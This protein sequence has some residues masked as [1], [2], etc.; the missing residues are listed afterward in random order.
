MAHPD[1]NQ[2]IKTSRWRDLSLIGA[3]SVGAFVLAS[4]IAESSVRVLIFV[5]AL[6]IF[7][8]PGV[9]LA[10]RLFSGRA[11]F[12]RYTMGAALGYLLGSLSASVF[13]RAG[14]LSPV[15]MGLASL[16]LTAVLA[17]W[18]RESKTSS[19]ETLFGTRFWLTATLALGLGLVAMPFLRV[20]EQT[21]EGDAYRAYFSA[22]LMTHLSVV[23][24]LQK[25]DFPPQNPF[26][27]G[28][29]LGY[30]WLFFLFPALLG[31]WIGNQQALLL[32]DLAG[33]C[34]FA[35]LAFAAANRLASRPNLAFGAVGIGLVAASYEGVAVLLRAAW[36]GEPV[37]SFKSVNV[38]AFSRWF[39][40]LTSLDGLHR[41]LL[42]TPQHLYSYSL[43]LVLVL[44]L[45]HGELRG[46]THSVVAGFLVGGMAGMSIV[47]A[48]IVGPWLVLS[49]FLSGGDRKT[50]LRDLLL[51]GVTA[52]GCLAWYFELGFFGDAGGELALRLPRLAD[53]PAI[54]FL[55]AGPLFL[56]GL[57]ALAERHL[58]RLGW[59]AGIAF[60]ATLFLDIGTA[61]GVWLAWRAGSVLLIALMLMV[62][63]TLRN[64]RPAVLLVVLLPATLTCALDLFNAQDITNRELSRGEFRWTTVVDPSDADALAWIR[65]HSA[66]EA[67]VQWDV[68]ARE[69]GEWA[70]IPA[71]AERRLAVGFPIFLLDNRRY[72]IRER[73]LRPM[74]VSS[75]PDEAHRLAKEAGIDYL[76][77]GSRE[78]TLRGE[79]VRKF[80]EAPE[81]FRKVYANRQATVFQVFG[82]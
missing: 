34:L 14:I 35:A 57:P 36:V 50:L 32:I 64:A 4:A 75:D 78:L 25:G 38:D 67:I 70:L 10:H 11:R 19:S 23:A 81:L 66:P 48:M 59:L 29:A 72:R 44:L 16:G 79:R 71:L 82:S 20:G 13:Y 62:A 9:F 39:F 65:T 7:V 1:P 52:L 68:R 43:L 37:G 8:L 40:E 61:P 54:L 24:E 47:T 60:M 77:I 80:W 56:L 6:A 69:P 15:S 51:I 42:Y 3:I 17:F 63:L 28:Q 21:P 45:S 27:A 26:Y 76:I 18:F 2:R 12:E 46:A 31:N 49:R 30:Q 33:C 22:D 41:S 58:L 73:R 53:I 5:S 55:E 74:F